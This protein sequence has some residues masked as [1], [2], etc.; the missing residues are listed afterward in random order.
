MFEGSALHSHDCD[1]PPGV[2]HRWEPC[3]VLALAILAVNLKYSTFSFAQSLQDKCAF[4]FY[5]SDTVR[6]AHATTTSPVD[7][8]GSLFEDRR[9][10]WS[11]VANMYRTYVNNLPI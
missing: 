4:L 11:G 10:Q 9:M 5:S 3:A 2:T 1:C 6:Q 8:H 7:T